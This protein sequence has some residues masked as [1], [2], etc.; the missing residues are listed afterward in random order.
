MTIQANSCLNA[1]TA[2]TG[3]TGAIPLFPSVF[4]I[5]AARYWKASVLALDSVAALPD[6]SPLPA[7]RPNVAVPV[8]NSYRAAPNEQQAHMT[9]EWIA[10]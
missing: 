3:Q 4:Q 9:T 6:S 7:S 1:S 8:D 5:G 2:S 10:V